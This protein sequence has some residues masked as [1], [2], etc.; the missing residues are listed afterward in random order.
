MSYG[1]ALLAV[2]VG[3]VVVGC[4]APPDDR[5]TLDEAREELEL[6]DEHL[7]DLAVRSRDAELAYK[8]TGKAEYQAIVDKLDAKIETDGKA[9]KRL[10]D[11]VKTLEQQETRK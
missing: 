5:L 6:C 3:T 11:R 10:R 7:T 4:M 1:K 9:Y 2:L 8:E